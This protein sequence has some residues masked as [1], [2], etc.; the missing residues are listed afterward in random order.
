MLK[1]YYFYFF[2]M[3][4]ELRGISMFLPKRYLFST[5]SESKIII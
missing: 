4:F 3:K 1:N 5:I 2:N